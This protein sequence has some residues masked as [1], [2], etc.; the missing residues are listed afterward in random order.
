MKALAVLV[1]FVGTFLVVQGYYAQKAV[2]AT[3]QAGTKVVYVPRSVYEEQMN[4]AQTLKQQFRSMFEDL[5]P[6]PARA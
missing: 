4:P 2:A 1:L 5:Q 3:P 6:W